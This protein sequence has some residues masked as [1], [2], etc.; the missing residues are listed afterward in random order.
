MSYKTEKLDLSCLGGIRGPDPL[1]EVGP[2]R[3][4]RPRQPLCKVMHCHGS[5]RVLFLEHD[6][7]DVKCGKRLDELGG[8]CR[9][10]GARLFEPA[11][12]TSPNLLDF[13]DPNRHDGATEDDDSTDSADDGYRRKIQEL[14]DIQPSADDDCQ[15]HMKPPYATASVGGF[16]LTQGTTPL[17]R[18]GF[19]TLALFN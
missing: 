4:E 9:S 3:F 17:C 18:K 10:R 6:E 1:C 14:C 12:F 16:L 19:Y 11:I 5:S 2:C 7:H 13:I 8:E 15:Q